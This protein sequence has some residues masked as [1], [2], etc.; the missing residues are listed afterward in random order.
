M[1]NYLGMIFAFSALASW[2]FGDFFIQKTA[3]R[4]GS[5]KALFF[6]GAA[7]S[8]GLF[9][10]VRNEIMFLNKE[11]LLLLSVLGVIVIIA[12]FFDFEA[13][14]EGKISIVEP[15]VS[16]EL[17]LTV[18]LSMVLANETLSFIQLLLVGVVFVGIVLAITEHHTHL[19][20]HKRIFE[21]GVILAAIGAIGMALVNFLVGK[22]SQEISALMTIWFTHSLLAVVCGIYLLLKGE[23]GKLIS[24]FKKHPGLIVG[25]SFLDN[26]GWVSFAQATT[27][28][29]IAIA[30]TVSESYI[31]MTVFLGLAI[32]KEK[33]KKH[34]ILGVILVIIGVGVL[35]YIS[36]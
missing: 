14:K 35:S 1:S 34:Q 31:A 24:D 18:G 27:Y 12:G 26:L 8:A 2:G 9:P 5:L 16:L 10:F 25:Q 33:L 28:I 13:L 19:H 36:T 21:K 32:N 17:P 23:F 11:N 4:I 6:I 29:P 7:G 20:Y 15:I 3:R 30:T 22:S